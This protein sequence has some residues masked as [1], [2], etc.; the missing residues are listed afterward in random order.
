[1]PAMSYERIAHLY[2]AYVQVDFDLK[3][4]LEEAQKTSGKVLELMSGTGRVSIPLIEAGVDL[5]CI[6]SS[7]GMLKVLRNKIQEKGISATVIEMDVCELFLED[8]YDLIFI[9]FHSFAE[10]TSIS[11]QR[12]TLEKIHQHLT[13]DGRFICTLHNPPIRLKRVDGSLRLLG[14]FP[15]KERNEVLFLW[16]VENYIESKN[17]VK[18]Q[19]FYEIYGGNGQMISKLFLDT[20]FYVH[21]KNSFEALVGDLSFRVVNIYGN[22]DW[23]EFDEK[24]SPVMIWSLKK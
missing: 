7:P 14:K 20:K 13:I 2:D 8:K 15:L 11:Q 12:Q 24:T 1:M 17:M 19:Q 4:F 5:T 22:Y 6:D 18:G 3:F 10:I 16:L 23:G 21:D 9:P